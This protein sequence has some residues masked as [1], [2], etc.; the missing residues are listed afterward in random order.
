[1]VG[2]TCVDV[3]IPCIKVVA[4]NLEE[5]DVELRHRP[6]PFLRQLLEDGK[7]KIKFFA[8]EVAASGLSQ[9]GIVD[10]ISDNTTK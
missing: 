6:A 9:R 5:T 1:M 8:L 3:A 4:G 10:R 2:E 7:E